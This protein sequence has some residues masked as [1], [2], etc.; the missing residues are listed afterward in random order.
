MNAK[1]LAVTL[2]FCCLAR[3]QQKYDIDVVPVA[4][5][6]GHRYLRPD[7]FKGV[8]AWVRSKLNQRRCLIPQDVENDGSAQRSRWRVWQ[9]ETARLGGLLLR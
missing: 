6:T 7:D 9:A 8:P 5:A 4:S 2:A 1:A 3:A